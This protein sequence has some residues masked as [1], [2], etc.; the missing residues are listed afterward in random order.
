MCTCITYQN[1]DFY[2][3]RNLDL[4]CSFGEQVVVA[5]RNFPLEFRRAGREAHHYAMIGMASANDSFPLYAEA[6]NEK[7]LCMAGL[8]FPGNAY[9][10]EVS[11]EG[12]EIA[13]FEIIAWILGKYASV[14]EAEVSLRKIKIV[15]IAFLPQMP[16][17]PLHWM[18]AD[19][20]RCL[21]LEAV[22]EGLKIH[23]NPFGVLTNNPPFEYHK[24]NMNNYLN[25]SARNPENRFSDRLELKG[26]SQG[27]GAVGLPGDASSASRFV[28][29]AFLRWNSVSPED[30]DSNVSQ[31]FHILD[32]VA[33]V[34]GAVVTEAGTYDITT[35][36]CCVN[37]RTGTYYY[38]TYDDSRIRKVDLYRE[39]PEGSAL[40]FFQ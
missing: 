39:D 18:L 17:A 38:K 8:N 28:R 11:G 31:F 13:S 3:G 26:Y 36:S 37:T 2:F 6:V 35:Y 10:R 22:R 27:M 5:P 24:I 4:D 25:L 21:V 34:R 16:P 9:Y 29:A 14:A 30:E 23:E 33:M 20:E 7:G 19:K 1:K 12:I 40:R 32:G 15:D